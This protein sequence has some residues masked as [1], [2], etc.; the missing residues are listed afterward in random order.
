MS[1]DAD[2]AAIELRA[3][4]SRALVSPLGAELHA[5][6]VGEQ[7]LLWPGDPAS[8]PDRA[9]SLFPVVGWARDGRIRVGGETHAMGVHGFARELPFA[10][11]ERGPDRVRLA[12]YA[13]PATRRAYPFDWRLDLAYALTEGALAVELTVRNAGDGAMPYACGLHPGFRWPFA[14]GAPEDYRIEFECDEAPRVP[15][16]AP[17]GL[18]SRDT[19]SVPLAGTHLPLSRALLG[20]EALCFL[21]ARS[22]GL[23]FL[24]RDGAAIAMRLD[25]FPHIAL[26]SRPPGAFLCLEAWTGHGDPVG[27]TGELKDKPSQR[28]LAAGG[29]ARHRAQFSFQAA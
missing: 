17:G 4:R 7:A 3:G 2:G 27:F 6:D 1:G 25:G 28:L 15:V 20:S 18:F 8:W 9:P 12:T 24:H 11:V 29:I 22:R 26:W 10:A 14:G 5:W 16:I 21:D 23:R 19:R 13:T